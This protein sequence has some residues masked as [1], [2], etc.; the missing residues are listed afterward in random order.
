M[1][2]ISE[3]ETK[4]TFL[5]LFA[6]LVN[7]SLLYASTCTTGGT[8]F[9]VCPWHTTKPQMH[10]ANVVPWVA[11]VISL[12]AKDLSAKTALPCAIHRTHGTLFVVCSKRPTTEK[13]GW[14]TAGVLCRVPNSMGTRQMGLCLPC[15]TAK[16]HGKAC[17]LCRVPWSGHTANNVF[18]AMVMLCAVCISFRHMTHSPG[19]ATW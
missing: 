17:Q 1:V 16:A 3:Y 15:A 5:R 6:A 10:T 13:R 19:S 2:S 11:H 12:T 8:L 4:Q 14:V 7:I 18:Q 9:A